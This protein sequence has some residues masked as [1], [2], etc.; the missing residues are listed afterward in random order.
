MITV[1]QDGNTLLFPDEG[2]VLRSTN[3]KMQCDIQ[4]VMLGLIKDP[5]TGMIVADSASNYED[6][7]PNEE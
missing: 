1:E 6:K 5:E 3:G 2:K 7:D 4:A